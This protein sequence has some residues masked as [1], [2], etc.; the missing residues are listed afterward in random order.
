VRIQVERFAEY[1]RMCI[2]DDGRGFDEQAL[3]R[4]TKPTSWGMSAMRERAHAFGGQ[5]RVESRAPGAAIV[6]DVPL[7]HAD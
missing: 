6:V 7:E 4:A 2:E 1:V 3:E 5:L